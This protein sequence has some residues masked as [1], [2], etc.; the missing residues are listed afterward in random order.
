MDIWRRKI[1]DWS[2][3]LGEP[4]LNVVIQGQN[5]VKNIIV[6]S[7]ATSQLLILYIY[8]SSKSTCLFYK[9]A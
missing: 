6:K 8:C 4:F 9:G 1:L 2:I 7:Y 5:V 3:F